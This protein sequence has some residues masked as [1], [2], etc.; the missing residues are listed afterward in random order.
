MDAAAHDASP[1]LIVGAGPTGLAAAMSLARA[2][3]PVRLIDKALQPNPYSRA[4][5]I[6][7]R[8]L[9]LFEQHR[10]IEPFLELGHR[11][12]IANL[13]SNGM[14]LARLDFDPLHT[15]YPYL[16]FLDQSVTERLLTEHLATLGVTVERGVELMMFAQGSAS[17]QVTLR[18]ADGHTETLRPSYVIAADGAHSTIRHRLGLSFAGKTFEQTFLL[19]DV[20]AETD[21]PED[22]FHI[23]ASGEGLVALFPMGHGRHRLIADHPLEP[24]TVPEPATPGGLGE[25]PLNRVSPPSLSECNAL[26]ARRV[27]ER[28]DVSELAWS[29]YFHLNSRMVERLRVG[30]IFLAGDAAH[31]HSPAG[32]QG[33]N[34]GIQEAFNLGWKLA[35]VLKGAA[36]DRLLDTYHHERHPIERDVLRQTGFIT[37]MAE[38]D[39]GPLKLLRERVMP[40][41]AALGPLRDAARMTISELSVQY[42]R[43]PLTLERLLDGGPRAGE[44]APDALVHVVDG[45]LGRAPGVGCIFDLHDPAFFSLFLLVPPLPVDG[46]P[47]DP[48]AKH[49]PSPDPELERLAAEVEKL[50]PG[51]VR[52]W[53]VTDTSGEGAPSLSESYG[54]TRPS[55]YLVRPDGYI[56]AR[57]RTGSDL[58]GLLRHCEAWFAVGGVIPEQAA[59]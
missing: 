51:A 20:H 11:A 10:L 59:L 22:E 40:V 24:T 56:S 52:I 41:L 9:E 29:S 27:R 53:R 36:P 37:H 50:L 3:I 57:G 32:A 54:R 16:L 1:V 15:R 21:W 47:L 5:G 33:M 44:R 42:R 8:T 18:R 31:V 35:R 39:H 13:F 7:A 26:I 46:T 12:R 30:R 28:V 6:Q 19:A 45:P 55:F 17:I 2:H 58:H 34:T 38:A 49:A 23:F 48:A 43:S 4:I 14:R 25:P